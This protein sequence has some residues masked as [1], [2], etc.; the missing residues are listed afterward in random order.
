[1]PDISPVYRPRKPRASQYYLSVEDHFEGFEQVYDERF[2]VK[3][4]F[5]RAYVKR[6]IYR[7]LDCGILHN[8]FARVKCK[9]CG[10]EYLLAFS[11]KR[12]HFCPS[13]HQ[14]RVV[15]FGEWLCEEVRKAGSPVGLPDY[16]NPS[17]PIAAMAASMFLR[18][19]ASFARRSRVAATIESLPVA[20]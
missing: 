12:R 18:A 11:C 5:F 8:G 16:L 4:G 17:L 14:K 19:A 7:Y 1:M 20:V 6:V 15:E 3:Y 9:D 2:T 13:C 10:H